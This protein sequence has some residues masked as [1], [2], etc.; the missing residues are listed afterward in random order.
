[1]HSI[2]QECSPTTEK[3]ADQPAQ[4]NQNTPHKGGYM[5]NMPKHPRTTGQSQQ[6]AQSP[7]P[8]TI[9]Q[10]QPGKK[11]NKTH[12][13]PTPRPPTRNTRPKMAGPTKCKLRTT[14]GTC[15]PHRQSSRD[16]PGQPGS[17]AD[18]VIHHPAHHHAQGKD[19]SLTSRRE[20]KKGHN[21]HSK[22]AAL[23]PRCRT[24]NIHASQ[25]EMT[26]PSQAAVPPVP[27]PQQ[28]HTS[29]YTLVGARWRP[30]T[31]STHHPSGTTQQT[32]KPHL[33]I[34]PRGPMQPLSPATP[35]LP[36]KTW[37]TEPPRTGPQPRQHSTPNSGGHSPARKPTPKPTK[38]RE[39]TQPKQK[40]TKKP[41]PVH[42]KI[43][44][45]QPTRQTM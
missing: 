7:M 9:P 36:Y 32:S 40:P 23:P 14:I 5:T 31:P 21:T 28:H 35:A 11:G 37:R 2:D 13:T 26:E 12:P 29:F 41:R 1:M 44:P 38:G 4:R 45:G 25:A 27:T 16:P 24:T 43:S 42:A 19:T 15:T 18:P 20:A 22:E 10:P 33:S 30:P 6:S 34:R 8:G 39:P 17:Q 3:R